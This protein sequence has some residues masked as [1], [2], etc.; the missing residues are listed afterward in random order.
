MLSAQAKTIVK[1]TAPVLAEHGLA[2]TQHFYHRMFRDEPEL[3]NIF[4]QAHQKAGDQPRALANAVYAYAANI[5]QPEVLGKA[6][7]R[8]AHKHASLQIAPEQYEIVGRHLL[9][10][11]SEVLG[12]AATDEVLSA[13]GEAYWQLANIL[14]DREEALYKGVENLSGGWR[15]W[16]RFQIRRKVVESAEITSF[17]LYPVDGGRVPDFKPGQYISL[18]V[19]LPELGLM[20]PRQYSLSDAPNGEYFRISVKR[21]GAKGEAPQG[22][23]SNRLHDHYQEGDEIELS[24]PFGDFWLH[25]QR[26]NPAVFISGGVGITPLLSMLAR[27]TLQGSGRTLVFVHGA[28]NSRVRGLKSQLDQ[29]I[30]DNPNARSFLFLESAQESDQQG[31]DY[32]FIGPVDL[33]PIRSEILL[34]QADYYLCGPIPFI[35]LHR[36]RLKTMGVAADQIHYEVFGSDTLTD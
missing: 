21:E 36:D 2:I 31:K 23:V 26:A 11:I 35:R 14:I 27:L 13:W 7:E 25:E 10:S 32:D 29:V 30:R 33:E 20:Q 22:L 9:A 5:D 34:P 18:R 1:A 24:P 8:I 12:E 6:I 4:N 17:Y 15:G 19:F 28:R 16:R 3:K